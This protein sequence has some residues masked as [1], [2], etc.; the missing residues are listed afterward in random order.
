MEIIGT[1]NQAGQQDSNFGGGLMGEK[2]VQS[3]SP[4][5][6]A[7]QAQ[8]NNIQVNPNP[9]LQSV[10]NPNIQTPAPNVQTNDI[11]SQ[12][13]QAVEPGLFDVDIPLENVPSSNDSADYR[14]P[15]VQQQQPQ[16]VMATQQAQLAEILNQPLNQPLPNEVNLQQPIQQPLQQPLQQPIVDPNNLRQPVLSAEQRYSD[17]SREAK[18]LAILNTKLQQQVD[19]VAPV[20]PLVL[21]LKESESLRN[22]VNGFYTQGNIAPADV[23]K[24]LKLPADFVFNGEEAFK[25]PNSDSA[26]LLTT[27]ID[28]AANA[29]AE[30]VR[31]EIMTNLQAQAQKE[32]ALQDRQRFQ[33]TNQLSPDQMTQIG[34]FAQQHQV[35]L[36]DIWYLMNRGTREQN[37]AQNVQQGVINQMHNAREVMPVSINGVAPNPIDPNSEEAIFNTAFPEVGKQEGFFDATPA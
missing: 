10:Q 3:T 31:T 30:K 26:K 18:R 21:K 9:N 29:R 35:T 12:I 16:Q 22:M 1:N 20:M 37:I 28:M 24:M 33:A 27:T 17:S 36:D 6:D 15:Q 2:P 14:Q 34:Q 8:A 7:L 5:L 13:S 23:Q 19:A 32:R 11:F 25:D 4:A